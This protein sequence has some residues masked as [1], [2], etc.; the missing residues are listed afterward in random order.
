[1]LYQQLFAPG[2]PPEKL[3]DALAGALEGYG[4]RYRTK[5]ID[6]AGLRAYLEFST[7]RAESLVLA[8]LD[9]LT[10]LVLQLRLLVQSGEELAEVESEILSQSADRLETPGVT[11]D[12]LLD[13][14]NSIYPA[15]FD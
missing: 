11:A 12:V 15:L 10:A 2:E 1:L 3:R 8:Y 7:D 13:F 9:R 6:G 4:R 5:R 14:A